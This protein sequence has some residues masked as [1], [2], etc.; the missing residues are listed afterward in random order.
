M[1]TIKSNLDIIKNKYDF[2]N[3]VFSIS[4]SRP[5]KSLIDCNLYKEYSKINTN[6]DILNEFSYIN[7]QQKKNRT[8]SYTRNNKY[9]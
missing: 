3:C 9:F 8:F 1:F 6:L 4:D 5:S 7:N 2:N